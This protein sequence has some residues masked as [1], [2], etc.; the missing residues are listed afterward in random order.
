MMHFRDLTRG[1]KV[2]ALI[3]GL[4]GILGLIFMVIGGIYKIIPIDPAKLNF[5]I[6]GV[7]Q[8]HTQATVNNYKNLF[9][10]VFGGFGSL[11]FFVGVI[12]ALILYLVVRRSNK[13]D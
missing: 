1:G 3:S 9:Y 11:L 6:N 8:P 2:L 10:T 13:Q 4:F 12:F 5:A 7:M